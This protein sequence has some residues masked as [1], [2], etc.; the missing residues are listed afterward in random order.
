MRQTKLICP[1][2]QSNYTQT[3]ES[4]YLQY[5]RS[6]ARYVTALEVRVSPPPLRSTVFV[7]LCLSALTIYVC[8][9]L[10]PFLSL[11]FGLQK[12]GE[13]G[14]FNTTTLSAALMAGVSLFAVLSVR[15]CA[16]NHGPHKPLMDQWALKV[17]CRRCAHTFELDD[18]Q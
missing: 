17:L 18:D 14:I 13:I 3:F 10:F 11:E 2:C 8:A 7:P 12:T 6:D 16:Y 5:A 9:L 1:N 15:A 4:V